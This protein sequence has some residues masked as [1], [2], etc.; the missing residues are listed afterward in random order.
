MNGRD[1]L[2]RRHAAD[3]VLSHQKMFELL[4]RTAEPFDRADQRSLAFVS[5]AG[6]IWPIRP[7]TMYALDKHN[8]H[9][10]RA[11]KGDLQRVC[12]FSPALSGRETHD[13]DG[14][15]KLAD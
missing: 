2:A 10:L 14:S 13:A 4:H 12:T 5:L 11:T 9:I 3:Q 7:G 6:T 8:R 1:R 15:Y